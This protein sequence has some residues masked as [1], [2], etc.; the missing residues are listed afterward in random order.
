[1]YVYIYIYK[2]FT[3]NQQQQQQQQRQR[4]RQRQRQQQQQ[5]QHKQRQQQQQQHKQRQQQQQQQPTKLLNFSH[6]TPEESPSNPLA[7]LLAFG[8]GPNDAKRER[9][10]PSFDRMALGKTHKTESLVL[11]K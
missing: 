10:N 4:Q 11:P 8:R 2:N 7:P 9:P 1:M 6:K 5:Q 3:K